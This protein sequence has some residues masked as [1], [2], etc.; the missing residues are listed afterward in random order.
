MEESGLKA[1]TKM[2]GDIFRSLAVRT[3]DDGI[4]SDGLHA[5]TLRA[6]ELASQIATS[7]NQYTLEYYF[8]AADPKDT[9]QLDLGTAHSYNLI[10]VKTGQPVSSAYEVTYGKDGK[11][12]EVLAVVFPALEHRDRDGKVKVICKP[13]VLAKF[14]SS[15]MRKAKGRGLAQ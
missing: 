12:G 14:C 6:A 15:V 4:D 5:I 13:T 7:S 8:V 2:M 9:R 1:C 10:D 11:A 3:T